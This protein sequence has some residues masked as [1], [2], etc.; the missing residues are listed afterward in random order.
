LHRQVGGW[1]EAMAHGREAEVAEIAAYHLD[2]ALSYGDTSPETRDRC[3]Q[4]LFAAGGAALSR[5][6]GESAR[7]LYERAADLAHTTPDRARALIGLGRAELLLSGSHRAVEVLEGARDAASEA[8]DPR[9]LADALGL[10]SRASW[11]A[12]RY[13]EAMRAATAAVEALDGLDETPQ[14]A[15]AVARLSQLEMLSGMTRAEQRAREAIEVARRVG[16]THAEL[17]GRTNLVVNLAN[18]GRFPDV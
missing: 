16:D 10:Y 11:L 4:L 9:L 2:Q 12:G 8:G 18:R 6:A 15:R 14:L 17:N 1:I 13:G 3:L 7:R 5:A